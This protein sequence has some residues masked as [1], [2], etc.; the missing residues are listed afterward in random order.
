MLSVSA[1]PE[2]YGMVEGGGSYP[3]N[4]D[5]VIVAHPVDGRYRFVEW[6]DHATVNPRRVRVV[7][8]T[9]FTAMFECV[10]DTG[11]LQ[12]IGTAV[13]PEVPFLLMPNPASNEVRL[14]TDGEGFEGGILTVRDAAG[15]EVLRRE[16]AHGT[17]TSSFGVADYPSGTYF[18]TLTTAK[19][20][21]T[22]K[23]VVEEN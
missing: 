8:D 3:Q 6:H 4:T 23:L 12:G 11:S 19:G 1:N 15:R 5:T 18:V 10:E 7:C 17:R 21:S 22:Q 16:L 14:E 13:T 20:S 9:A 2:E